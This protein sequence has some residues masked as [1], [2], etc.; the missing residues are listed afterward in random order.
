[1]SAPRIALDGLWRCLC[2]SVDPILASRILASP[3][4]ARPLRRPQQHYHQRRVYS[5]ATRASSRPS[6]FQ[7]P[8]N[9]LP[10]KHFPLINDAAVDPESLAKR[11]TS[12][13][14]A[15][16]QDLSG[17]PDGFL[18]AAAVAAYLVK[19][20][21]VPL[22]TDIY[23][24]L[25]AACR[26]T[27]ASADMLANLLGDM[28]ELGLPTGVLLCHDAL[29]ALAIHPNYLLRNEV[30]WA[31]DNNWS[32]LDPAG[33]CSVA[34]GLLRDGQ[35]EMA[36]DA[37]DDMVHS[38]SPPPPHIF[39]IFILSL[40]HQGF[41]DEAV[42]M[43]YE[44]LLIAGRTLP[45]ALW[46]LLLD[47]CSRDFHAPGT[48]YV[49]ARLPVVDRASIPNG[50]LLNIVNTAARAGDADM[51]ADAT[52]ALADRGAS[53][54]AH[55]YEALVDAFAARRDVPAAL[56][57]LCIMHT[58]L[59]LIGP[60][61]TRS[62]YILLSA[63][64]TLIDTALDALPQLLRDRFVPIAAYN[65]VLE[66]AAEARGFAAAYEIYT[67]MPLYTA[68]R[69]TVETL[70]HL[71]RRCDDAS[72]LRLIVS[73]QP[74]LASAANPVMFD[75]A[76]AEFALAGDLDLVYDCVGM[77]DN[78]KAW[79][80]RD[81]LLTVVRRSVDVSDDRLW[82]L[83]EAARARGQNIEAGLS[84]IIASVERPETSRKTVT[85]GRREVMST[86]EDPLP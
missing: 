18:P 1:M 22:N 37:F 27:A 47:I 81:T 77:Y 62:L 65:V 2:P 85:A 59:S 5:V 86:D 52:K 36:L 64:P 82:P 51:V 21:N 57:T 8:R 17:R 15:T 53:L 43:A 48:Q 69:P 14:M 45:R 55:H 26:D 54:A 79:L 44:K 19:E 60:G 67:A 71:L 38:E 66:A 31:M 39:D 20:R 32:S 61:S 3:S 63:E 4:V 25:V 74:R 30:L 34:L 75:R 83:I 84:R 35:V 49:W 23:H 9:A 33:R 46:L 76:V 10:K 7:P 50:T 56:R 70:V 58:A 73:E 24:S 13:L 29:E 42:R 78:G 6:S 40:A 41:H 16:L 12:D 28:K 11:S 68:D 72:A 80:S